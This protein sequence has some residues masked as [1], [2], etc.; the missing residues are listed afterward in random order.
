MESKKNQIERK[1]KEKIEDLNKEFIKKHQN[2][3]YCSE[4]EI[5]HIE[6]DE[7]IANF[8]EEMGY[9]EISKF[10]KEAKEYFWYS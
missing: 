6:F 8:L 9:K 3:K 1:Y 4:Q 7:L 2:K 10:Y 5:Y